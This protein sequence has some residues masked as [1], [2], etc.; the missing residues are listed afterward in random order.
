MGNRGSTRK[1]CTNPPRSPEISEI[2]MVEI[3]DLPVGKALPLHLPSDVIVGIT[4]LILPL[5]ILPVYIIIIYL[6]L[7]DC[8]L[9]RLQSYRVMFH[10]GVF[11]CIQLCI[12]SSGGI[13]T[14]LKFI[15]YDYPFVGML[16]GSI[17]NAAWV[18]LFPISLIIAITRLLILQKINKPD[19][20]LSTEIRV[21]A[22]FAR[23]E[24]LIFLFIL[25]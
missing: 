14:L 20:E 18:G 23:F 8:K 2:L 25:I 6:F 17:L 12:H 5:L 19:C 15:N 7:T 3:D 22:I 4:Y 1:D 21:G 24:I 16:L 9:S 13:L 10:L 11:D